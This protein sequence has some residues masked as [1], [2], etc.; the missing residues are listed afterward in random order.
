MKHQLRIEVSK[1]K[2]TQKNLDETIEK[3]RSLENLLDNRERRLYSSGQLVLHNKNRR[4]GTQ[5]LTNLRDISSSNPLKLSDKC[6]KWQT[7]VQ[8]NILPILHTSE[9]NDK[10]IKADDEVNSNRTLNSVR[11]ETMANLEQVRKYRL[12]KPLHKRTSSDDS[13]EKF[14]E[15]DF[16]ISENSKAS[17]NLQNSQLKKQDG[18]IN[19]QYEINV[20]KLKKIYKNQE[21]QNLN[22][23]L[24]KELTNSSR[25]SGSEIESESESENENQN[26]NKNK[27]E[28][29]D[30]D[31]DE[32][33]NENLKNNYVTAA[34]SRQ[35]YRRLINDASDTI[36]LKE[37][38]FSEHTNKL[39]VQNRK[40]SYKSD[41][42]IDTELQ[43]AVKHDFATNISN[44]QICYNSDEEVEKFVTSKSLLNGS[45]NID[46]NLIYEMQIQT[47]NVCAPY[48]TTE[49][50]EKYIF[51]PIQ[52]QDCSD[53]NISQ[54]EFTTESLAQTL[55]SKDEQ[56]NQDAASSIT[57]DELES[58][59]IQPK[60]SH[61][62]ENRVKD[63]QRTFIGNP[64]NVLKNL[65][66]KDMDKIEI[67]EMETIN[68]NILNDNCDVETRNKLNKQE[69]H[70]EPRNVETLLNDVKSHDTDSIHDTSVDVDTTSKISIKL[71]PTNYI[72]EQLL[73]SMKAIDDNEN[74]EFLSQDNKK[75]DIRHKKQ[76]TDNLF[77]D[78]PTHMKKKQDIIRDIF[79][80]DAIK[81][82]SIGSC[83]KL[84]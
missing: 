60:M 62:N 80:T 55:E 36:H 77:Q 58:I 29:E 9:L 46:Q 27:N 21:Y 69:P 44:N 37:L 47:K 70:T 16:T 78:I 33:E 64:L 81:N 14:K 1:R 63:L 35:L 7:N 42:E 48:N 72:K 22:E 26:K 76:I 49:N 52:K 67:S 84:H 75:H 40:S 38:T 82:E 45:Q 68:R 57:Y 50:V 41:S 6:E 8:D 12:Q 18:N 51:K 24:K 19:W 74:F 61:I 31:E 5:S 59:D 83:N 2:E 34:N 79:D 23:T 17:I 30:E 65:D 25:D 66:K 32:N 4:F 13:E 3:L 43:E 10:D 20:D 15:L 11:T 28:N 73:A 53:I 71:K 56:W 54:S 39:K